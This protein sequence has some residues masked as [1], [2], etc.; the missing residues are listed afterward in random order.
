MHELNWEDDC[1]I[2]I[3]R[4]KAGKIKHQSIEFLNCIFHLEMI[5][6]YYINIKLILFSSLISIFL[7][8]NNMYGKLI[9]IVTPIFY[10]FNK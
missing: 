4:H 7:L 2:N 10:T 8:C 3:Y 9:Q 5:L 1:L 6:P